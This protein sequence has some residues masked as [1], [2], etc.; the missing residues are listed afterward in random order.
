MRTDKHTKENAGSVERG[1]SRRQA[2]SM[3]GYS[4]KTLANFALLGQG[5][6]MRK[7]RGKCIYLESELLA[8]LRGLP[9]SGGGAAA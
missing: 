3:T 6:P 1:L 4:E 2:A 5:P 8:W 9:V 7:F